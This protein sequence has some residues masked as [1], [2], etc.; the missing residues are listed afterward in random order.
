[1]AAT[2][3]NSGVKVVCVVE[4]LTCRMWSAG[5]TTTVA[6]PS[7]VKNDAPGAREAFTAALVSQ[8]LDKQRELSPD[9]LQWAV[10]AMSAAAMTPAAQI[11]ESMPSMSSVESAGQR[12]VTQRSGAT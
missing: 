6:A 4:N 9:S 11:S 2:L 3:C 10:S 12:R 5:L 7:G 1:V 8:L